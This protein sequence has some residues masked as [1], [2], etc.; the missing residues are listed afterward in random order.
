MVAVVLFAAPII[1][2]MVASMTYE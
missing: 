2:R 1:R